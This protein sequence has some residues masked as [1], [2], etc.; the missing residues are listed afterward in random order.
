MQWLRHT[1]YDPPTLAEQQQDTMRQERI[2]ALAAQADAK[3]ASKPSALDAPDKQQ[4]MQM[5]QSRDPDSGVVPMNLEQERGEGRKPVGGTRKMD[6]GGG[7][8]AGDVVIGDE[9][10]RIGGEEEGEEEASELLEEI[11]IV[12]PSAKDEAPT[13]KTRKRMKKEP[14]DSPWKHA[15]GNPGE[16]WQ[17]TGWSPGPAKRRS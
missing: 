4:P 6:T 7:G 3:W 15:A 11:G 13:L 2:K 8:G 5:L 12:D 10:K 14:K 17:P 16:E 9:A 1:R